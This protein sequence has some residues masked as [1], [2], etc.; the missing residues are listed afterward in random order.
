MTLHK[1]V[2]RLFLTA[3]LLL[4]QT[5]LIEPHALASGVTPP[6]TA[7][8]IEIGNAH[9]STYFQEKHNLVAIK[10]NAI[11]RCNFT[12]SNVELNVK[13]Y[14]V[15]RFK[16]YLVANTT[17]VSKGLVTSGTR[18]KNQDTHFICKNFKNSFF[19]GVASAV[20]TVNGRRVIAPPV[21]SEEIVDRNCGN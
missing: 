4:T 12:Q 1:H 14:K 20:A 21:R 8:H 13:I 5:F 11:S 7:C 15:G 10:V 16:N 18:V 9:L 19:F 2:I 17:V 3:V 6:R